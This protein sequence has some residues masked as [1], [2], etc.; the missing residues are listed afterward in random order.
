MI[1]LKPVDK[2]RHGKVT[3]SGIALKEWQEDGLAT[4]S[5]IN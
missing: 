2:L 1:F 5:K 3:E 4:T